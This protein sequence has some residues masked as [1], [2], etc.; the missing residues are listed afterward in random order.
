[1]SLPTG[2]WLTVDVPFI[3]GTVGSG[4]STYM[5]GTRYAVTVTTGSSFDYEADFRDIEFGISGAADGNIVY[6]R[7][8]RF[9]KSVAWHVHSLKDLTDGYMIFNC[10]R[11]Q[12]RDDA[13]RRA[14]D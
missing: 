7:G 11:T 10:V 2:S 13:R 1:L 14:Y 8:I 9:Y 12:G 3:S 5:E 6:V 4:T